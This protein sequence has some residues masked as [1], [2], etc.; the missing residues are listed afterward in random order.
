MSIKS[1]FGANLKYYRKR[2]NLSQEEL[3]EQ[4]EITSKHLSTIETGAVFVS[5]GLL[6]R[7]TKRLGVSASALFYAVE[8]T[9]IDDSLLTQIDQ[10]VDRELAKTAE[11]IKLKIHHETVK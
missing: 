5:A 4:V 9:S 2:M 7:F 6:E 1:I 8:E 3:A 10:I 11:G